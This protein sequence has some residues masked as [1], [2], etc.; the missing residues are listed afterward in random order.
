[1]A[2]ALAALAL[3]APSAQAANGDPVIIP[4]APASTDTYAVQSTTPIDNGGVPWFPGL[5]WAYH[6]YVINAGAWVYFSGDTTTKFPVVW[7]DAGSGQPQPGIAGGNGFH[8][9]LAGEYPY[10]CQSV[11]ATSSGVGNDCFLHPRRTKIWV[12]GARPLLT[13][14]LASPDN[15][16]TPILYKFD[17]SKSFVC[18]FD[19]HHIVEYSFDFNADGTWDQVSPDPYAQAGLDPGDQVVLLKVKDDIGRTAT[20][21]QLVQV[22]KARPPAPTPEPA[23]TSSAGTNVISGVKF[24]KVNLKVTAKA[25]IK[26]SVLKRK[27]LVIKVTGLTKGDRVTAKVLNG[28]QTV[29]SGKGQA[30]SSALTFRLKVGKKSAKRLK[31]KKRV[32]RMILSVTVNGS[33]G[34]SS[35]KRLALRVSR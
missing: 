20:I 24:D 21:A 13:S 3:A 19:A 27:G 32:T 34:F 10:Y 15:T 16:T 11:A 25:K 26:V 23:D 14:T 29:G 17:A 28:K 7:E 9:P 35:T 33:D 30:R 22:P 2:A 5:D 31:L 18:D 8:F 4:V 12:I 6:G 1:M